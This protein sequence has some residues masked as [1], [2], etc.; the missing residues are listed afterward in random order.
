[1]IF[2]FIIS[3][4]NDKNKQLEACI[5]SIG[6]AYKYKKDCGIEILV[7]FQGLNK[8]NENLKINYPELVNFYYIE[9]KG[10]SYARNYAIR[11]SRGDFLVFL[12]D[13]AQIKE[14]FLQVLT[15]ESNNSPAEVFCGRI[16][17]CNTNQSFTAYF[18][19]EKRLFLKITD[20]RYFMGSSHVIKKEIIEK[21]GFYDEEFGAGSKYHGAE[22][23]DLFF[24]LQRHGIKI[25]YL[26]NLVFYHPMY[27]PFYSKAFN[28][29]YAIGAMFKKQIILDTKH[30]LIYL[31]IASNIF[32][33]S[34][35]RNIQ[36]LFFKGIA[37]KDRQFH[38][39]AAFIGMLKGF[40]E[41]SKKY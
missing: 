2:S 18:S 3:S 8:N 40:L 14:D 10:L 28:Y 6:K 31:F 39:K 41:Y 24:R 15:W 19:N 38:Y 4:L 23:S 22:E 21:I 37:I 5:S 32:L 34:F 9:K 29:A 16:L 33:R 20:F 17:E 11:K 35:L 7:A 25:Q 26:P 12:D 30:S 13:D 27:E 1:M 36:K